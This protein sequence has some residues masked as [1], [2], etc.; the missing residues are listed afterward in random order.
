MPA[1]GRGGA[2]RNRQVNGYVFSGIQNDQVDNTVDTISL[3]GTTL[4]IN[5]QQQR[6]ITA[7]GHVVRPAQIASC[8]EVCGDYS[9]LIVH[10][11]R[12]SKSVCFRHAAGVE[13][14]HG[15][16]CLCNECHGNAIENW[17]TWSTEP[18]F[19]F[20]KPPVAAAKLFSAKG[21][22][23]ENEDGTDH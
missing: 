16:L 3:D 19:R 6:V 22:V 17:N 12:C 20:P 15:M 13:T 18:G 10:C 23:H 4:E 11:D 14:P 21:S 5:H 8:C 1:T 9:E 7:N 2:P